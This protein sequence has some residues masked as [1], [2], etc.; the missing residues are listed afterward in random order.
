MPKIT[1]KAGEEYSLKLSRLAGASDGIAKKAIYEGAKVAATA[2]KNQ[3]RKVVS[4]QA[5]GDLEDSLGISPMKQEETGDWNA[6]IGFDGYDRK[7]VPNVLKA[8]VLESGTSTRQK[9]PFVRPAVNASKAQA[10]K[11]MEE[12]IDKSIETLMKK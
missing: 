4:D 1:F 11:A 9:H 3:L 8:R 10:V 7:G 2:I 12:S 5:T 6:K